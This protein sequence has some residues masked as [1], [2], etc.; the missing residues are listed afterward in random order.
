M[1]LR[2]LAF[3]FALGAS[4]S[5]VQAA[6]NLCA[7]DEIAVFSCSIGLKQAALCASADLSENKG[8]LYY[9]FGKPGAVELSYPEAN[10]DPHK[11]FTIATIPPGGG[12]FVR[13]TTAGTTYSI[14]SLVTKRPGHFFVDGVLV[15]RGKKVLADL[16]CHAEAL[17]PDN[18]GPIYKAK[19]PEDTDTDLRPDGTFPAL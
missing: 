9:R 1:R 10:A 11:T 5:A 16:K 4:T 18:W 15:S 6:A 3:A 13:F 8:T 7:S 2:T 14:Y 19:L 17:G 12:D